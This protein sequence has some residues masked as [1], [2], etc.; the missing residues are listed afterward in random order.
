GCTFLH[1]DSNKTGKIKLNLLKS[2]CA[3]IAVAMSNIMSN[4]KIAQREEEKSILLS[5][6]DEIAALRSRD[7]L[8]RV[9][10]TK[11]KVLFELQEFGIAQI[12]ED[13]ETY[14][15]FVMDL[16]DQTKSHSHFKEVTSAKYKITDPVF[17][18]IMESTD[19]ILLEVDT[20]SKQG[21][22]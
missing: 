4:E 6:S 20:L 10:N 5:L 21:G 18:V 11:I 8:L 7:D 16:D 13:G 14:S 12:D 3:Q 17:S 9:V 1:I 22:V 15:S 19:P 2:V